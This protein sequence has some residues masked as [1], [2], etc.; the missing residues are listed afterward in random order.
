MEDYLKKSGS[1][2]G[3]FF[4]FTW[5]FSHLR[6]TVKT[7]KPKCKT[8]KDLGI[9]AA[10]AKILEFDAHDMLQTAEKGCP[11]CQ[12]FR[13]G[14]EFWE[15]EQVS[16]KEKRRRLELRRLREEQGKK[17]IQTQIQVTTQLQ[18]LYVSYAMTFAAD[19]EH[20]ELDGPDLY[21]ELEIF[22]EKGKLVCLCHY[23][24]T[25]RR[26]HAVCILYNE[27]SLMRPQGT[28]ANRLRH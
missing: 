18:L 11:F 9:W 26:G 5:C 8:C 16:E 22:V 15:Q 4:R 13:A 7:L 14:L 12:L 24:D 27:P 17:F 25:R 19:K 28:R 1:K 2:R 6:W 21:R 23:R 10:W 20:I 3:R